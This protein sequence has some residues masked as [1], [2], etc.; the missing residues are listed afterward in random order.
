MFMLELTCLNLSSKICKKVKQ[1][2]LGIVSESWCVGATCSYDTL[3]LSVLGHY[4]PTLL[5]SIKNCINCIQGEKNFSKFDCRQIFQSADFFS[6]LR[7]IFLAK[8]GQRT[9]KHLYYLNLILCIF[10][11]LLSTHTYGIIVLHYAW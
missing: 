7:I 5:T 10:S 11:F 3:E 4:L 2:I 1:N 6:S 8:N 9:L